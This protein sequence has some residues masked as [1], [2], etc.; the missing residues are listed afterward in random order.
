[1]PRFVKALEKALRDVA[2]QMEIINKPE[3][4]RINAFYERSK[5]KCSYKKEV[6]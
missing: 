5:K 1:M 6:F 4:Q 3:I 2:F